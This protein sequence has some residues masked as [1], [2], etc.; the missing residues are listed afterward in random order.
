ML[1]LAVLGVVMILVLLARCGSTPPKVEQVQVEPTPVVLPPE[2]VGAT[3]RDVGTAL[4]MWDDFIF[5]SNHP[6]CGPTITK[7]CVTQAE[8]DKVHE[9]FLRYVKTNKGPRSTTDPSRAPADMAIAAR[10]F[11]VA[12]ADVIER[13]K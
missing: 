8:R 7:N 1:W 6:S 11:V 10:D 5:N 3:V 4:R 12:V 9:A 2:S 13:W